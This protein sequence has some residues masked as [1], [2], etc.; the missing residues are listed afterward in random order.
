MVKTWM[1]NVA[2]PEEI[3]ARMRA[4]AQVTP[5]EIAIIREALGPAGTEDSP[6]YWDAD[7]MGN[8]FGKSFINLPNGDD[9]PFSYY[10]G[11]EFQRPA[12]PPGAPMAQQEEV[13]EL[14]PDDESEEYGTQGKADPIS[15]ETTYEDLGA[16]LEQVRSDPAY[17]GDASLAQEQAII[18][19]MERRAMDQR[20]SQRIDDERS[21]QING[22]YDPTGSQARVKTWLGRKPF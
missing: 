17:G 18:T 22:T 4:G 9:D 16:M 8:G 11:D 15:P 7:K 3:M 20:N 6:G 13:G 2:S 5:Q 12:M 19:E 14:A 10:T 21:A 1:G